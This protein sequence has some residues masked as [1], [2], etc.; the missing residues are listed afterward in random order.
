[1]TPAFRVEALSAEHR[2]D[3]FVCGVEPLDRYFHE[4]VTQ[5]IR[6]RFANCF[7]ATEKT[8]DRIAGY[9][10]L[11]ATSIVLEDLPE[12]TRKKLPRY[13]TVP[14]VR[15]GRLAVARDFL[16]IGLGAALLADAVARSMNSDIAVYALIV[17]AKDKTAADFY[18]HHGFKSFGESPLM[19]YLPFSGLGNLLFKPKGK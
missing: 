15:I 8:T 1:M 2:R 9:Y 10:T 11:S 3:E 19:L 14:A 18:Q 17:D 5:D 13:P 4:Q 16:R 6:R 7:V 12:A